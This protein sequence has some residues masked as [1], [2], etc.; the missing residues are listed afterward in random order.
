M[1]T[2]RSKGTIPH[3]F[4]PLNKNQKEPNSQHW[5]F[6]FL[7]PENNPGRKPKIRKRVGIIKN[8]L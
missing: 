8:T 6:V 2:T 1:N 3:P 7:P 5:N 4:I